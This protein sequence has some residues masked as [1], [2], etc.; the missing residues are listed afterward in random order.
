[1]LGDECQHFWLYRTS[2]GRCPHHCLDSYNLVLIH[3]LVHRL[4]DRVYIMKVV[5]SSS[6]DIQRIVVLF[7]LQQK[8]IMA[9]EID[10]RDFVRVKEGR[11][12]KTRRN[13]RYADPKVDTFITDYK[14]DTAHEFLL[15]IVRMQLQIRTCHCD[16]VRLAPLVD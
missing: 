3:N 1:M 11:R 14:F 9:A 8:V 12:K 13:N 15:L 4:E 2:L 16:F 10:S 5:S 7:L 6:Q